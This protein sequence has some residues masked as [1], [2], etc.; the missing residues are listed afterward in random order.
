MAVGFAAVLV[1]AA[2]RGGE[3]EAAVLDVAGAIEHMPMCFTGLFGEGG[4]NRE[5]ACAGLRQRAVE[6]GKAQV[7]ADGE[8]EPSP[9]QVGEDTE[10]AR[11]VIARLA[12]AFAAREIDV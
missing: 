5:E 9:R 8:A 11:L 6:R 3:D 7:I 12:V 1:L 4:R 10:L 2:L